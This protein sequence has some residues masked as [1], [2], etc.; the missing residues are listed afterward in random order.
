MKVLLVG[1]MFRYSG[2]EV[3]TLELLNA[4]LHSGVK[5][6]LLV[7]EFTNEQIRQNHVVTFK[8]PFTCPSS[9]EDIYLK[10]G[11]PFFQFLFVKSL[12]QQILLFQPDI[13]HCTQFF[14]TPATWLVSKLT[15]VPYI[16]YVRDYRLV[17]SAEICFKRGEINFCGDYQRFLCLLSLTKNPIEAIYGVSIVRLMRRFFQSSEKI[18]VTSNFLGRVIKKILEKETVT[19]Y[20]IVTVDHKPLKQKK[21]DNFHILYCGR[22]SKTKGLQLLLDVIEETDNNLLLHI[23]GKGELLETI[24]EHAKKSQKIIYHG[25]VPTRTLYNIIANVDLVVVPSLWPEP[26]GRVIVESQLIGVPVIASRKGGIPEILPTHHLFNPSKHDLL[27]KIEEVRKNPDKFRSKVDIK[28]N[29]EKIV[30]KLLKIHKE[31]ISH[32]R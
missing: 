2:A 5:S 24:R 8:V 4:L 17:C 22:L 25:F 9:S 13:L 26:F 19:L 1:D 29:P 18:L 21:R 23:V 20:N 16:S 15:G 14:G 10:L 28:L 6:I 7:P 27:L 30:K 11:N 31:C 32:N 3:S 12:I